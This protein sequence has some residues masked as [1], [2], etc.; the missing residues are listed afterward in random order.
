MSVDNHT[1]VAS[2]PTIIGF[3][4]RT[5]SG[6]CQMGCISRRGFHHPQQHNLRLLFSNMTD[7][8]FPRRRLGLS[9]V[10]MAIGLI[11]V[12]HILI[13]AYSNSIPAL[14]GLLE[15]RC[16]LTATQS[17]WFTGFGALA[18]G[19]TQPLFAWLS[20]RLDTRL[21]AS[22]GLA[23][24]TVCFCCLGEANSPATL[25]LM[26][27]GGMLGVAMYHPIAASAMGQM[28]P[29]QRSRLVS[30][31]FVAGMAGSAGGAMV[32]PYFAQS[33]AGFG[34]FRWLILPGLILAGLLQLAVGRTSHRASRPQSINP[35]PTANNREHW[36]P[37]L[38]LYISS[39]LRFSVNLVLFY[40][41]LR[42]LSHDSSLLHPD[43]STK[44]ISDHV[45]PTLGFLVAAT[46]IGMALGGI[47]AGLF[48]TPYREKFALVAIPII[49]TPSVYLLPRLPLPGTYILAA[50]A[51]IGIAA[52]MPVSISVAQR[53]LPRHPSVASGFMLG[54]A[55]S[56]SMISVPIAQW[57]LERFGL[58]PVFA[59][60][61]FGMALSGLLLLAVPTDTFLGQSQD[62][63]S[64]PSTAR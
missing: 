50:L 5:Y 3:V 40:L 4:D 55:W 26:F 30:L 49:F 12:T 46:Q 36:G 22:W 31:F 8:S 39:V 11:V 9:A 13:D 27:G 20:D 44:Q 14:L 63:N 53:W 19:V 58:T 54:G 15:V 43:W 2:Q 1:P 17:A 25:F 28:I 23:L 57:G 47:G 21:F 7:V 62:S 60:T 38:L 32:S 37:L 24:A 18:S 41:F 45:A 64:L 51:G 61:A 59:V 48:V 33:E 42:W 56:M 34:S 10:P 29:S 35:A 52:T 6:L 16:G